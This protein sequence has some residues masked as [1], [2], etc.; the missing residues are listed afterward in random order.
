MIT[1]LTLQEAVQRLTM[2][3]FT[4]YKLARKGSISPTRRCAFSGF[5]SMD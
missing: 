2:S 1:L 5:M 3:Q 4:I